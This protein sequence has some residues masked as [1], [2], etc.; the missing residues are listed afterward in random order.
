M[1]RDAAAGCGLATQRIGAVTCLRVVDAI[2]TGTHEP[3]TSHHELLRG[4]TDNATLGRVNKE[5]AEHDYRTHEFG[6]SVLIERN[7]AL[8]R[9]RAA[10]GAL[11]LSMGSGRPDDGGSPHEQ[12]AGSYHV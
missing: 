2:L 8:P 9:R 5:L 6:D 7:A 12:R 1:R 3:G 4:F 11:Q 10:S